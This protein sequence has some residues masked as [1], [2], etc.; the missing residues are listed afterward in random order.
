MS[1][2]A[3]QKTWFAEHNDALEG[4]DTRIKIN[5]DRLD[6]P[7]VR[8]TGPHTGAQSDAQEE[9]PSLDGHIT[10]ADDLIASIRKTMER[11]EKIVSNLERLG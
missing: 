4:L 2:T 10:R 8:M 7:T 5:T 6:A 9:K 3:Q 1:E 11:L